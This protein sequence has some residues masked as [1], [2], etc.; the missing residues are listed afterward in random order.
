MLLLV[1]MIF[2]GFYKTYFNQFPDFNSKITWAHHLHAAIAS[3]WIM[4]LILQPFLIRNRKFTIHKMIGRLSYIV[5]PLLILSFLPMILRKIST[6]PAVNI[7]VPIGDCIILILM[8]SLAIY[9]RKK[10]SYHMRYMIGT[11]I[12]FIGPTFG[13]IG[14]LLLGLSERFTQ[15][16]QYTIIYLILL[17]L[18]G[19]D[20]KHQKDFRPYLLMLIIWVVHQIIFNFL[21][22]YQ[23]S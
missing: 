5:F 4:M 9:H 15:N 18:I 8:Y 17:G 20:K 1:P 6:A 16:I 14:A 13:R 3:V 23:K 2:L 21:F 10:M 11:A 7:F 19:I 12:V 22:G